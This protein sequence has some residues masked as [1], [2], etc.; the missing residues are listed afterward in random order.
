MH[1]KNLNPA[2]KPEWVNLIRSNVVM[3]SSSELYDVQQ[4][5]NVIERIISKCQSSQS[6]GYRIKYYVVRSR[7]TKI[8]NIP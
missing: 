5:V 8:E 6:Y 1:L 2:S 7:I 3:T 4:K